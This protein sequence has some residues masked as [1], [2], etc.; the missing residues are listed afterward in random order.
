MEYIQVEYDPL[1]Y[2]GD[3]CDTGYFVYVEASRV[4]SNADVHN[5]FEELTGLDS[6]HIIHFSLD[7]LYTKDGDPL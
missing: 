7:D 1:Y 6:V 2:G 4:K 3:Y 5:L